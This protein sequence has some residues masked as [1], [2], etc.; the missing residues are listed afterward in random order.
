MSFSAGDPLTTYVGYTRANGIASISRGDET[1]AEEFSLIAEGEGGLALDYFGTAYQADLGVDQLGNPVGAVLVLWRVRDRSY[2]RGTGAFNDSFD[3]RISGF[4][5]TLVEPRDVALAHGPG[6]LIVSDSGDDAIKVWGTTAG[7]DVPPLF[8]AMPGGTPWGLAYD[9]E[10]DRLYAALLDG[11]VAVFDDF[12]LAEPAAATRTIV[13]SLDGA[14][15]STTSLRGIALDPRPGIDR[16]VVSDV[17]EALNGPDGA[18]YVINGASL[19]SG[20]SVA[21]ALTGSATTL[22][23]PLDVVVSADG[24]VRVVDG[25]TERLLVFGPDALPAGAG[26]SPRDVPPGIVRSRENP[27]GLALEPAS[28]VRAIAALDDIEDP[29]LPLDAVA[30]ATNPMSGAGEV[31]TV[32]P[33]LAGPRMRTFNLGQPALSLTLDALGCAYVGTDDG[34]ATSIAAIH[35]FATERGVG[36]DTTFDLSRDRSVMIAAD[37]FDGFDPA[38]GRVVAADLN[39][40]TGRLFYSDA[41]LPGVRALGRS[42]GNEAR[43]LSRLESGFVAGEAEPRGLDYD[44]DTDTLWV[45]LSNGAIYVYENVTHAIGTMPDRVI[46]PSDAFG[47]VQISSDI[48][49]LEY[50]AT[51]DVLIVADRGQDA[52]AG[53]DGAIYRFDSPRTASGLTAPDA[54]VSGGLTSLDDPVSMAWNGSTLWVADRAAGEVRSYDEFLMASGAI[55]P[56]AVLAVPGVSAIALVPVG[57]APASGGSIF[58]D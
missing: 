50:D 7:G 15:Q 51:R 22:A 56:T 34:F 3:R 53:P 19:A 52:G 32:D 49:D 58:E 54:V 44:A 2:E 5:T 38:L 41:T 29:S 26:A 31:F 37:P 25:E 6:A 43:D 23:D 39:E 4:F 8:T 13:P 36:A 42:A 11:T 40:A 35:R 16:L 45:G 55:A 18:L 27:V 47:A 33:L 14:T 10:S 46:T 21:L 57:I 12:V 20:P 24:R 30:V 17:G 28:P 9:D 1:F 48:G